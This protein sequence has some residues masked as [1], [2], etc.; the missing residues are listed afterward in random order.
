ML[1]PRIYRAGFVA[2]ALALVVLAFSLQNQPGSLG[3]TLPPDAFNGQ[4]AYASMLSVAASDPLR[5]PGSEGDDALATQVAN[6]LGENGFSVHKSTFTGRTV[7]GSRTLVNVTAIRPG[8]S[9]GTILVVAHRDALGSP[10]TAELSGTATL[11][12]LARDLAGETLN[13]TV[14]LASTSGSAGTAGAIRLASTV[15]GR[16]DAVIVL[17]DLATAHVREPIIVPWSDGQRVAPPLLRNTVAAALGAQTGLRAGGTSIA[18]QFVHLAFPLTISEQGPFGARGEPA[19]LLSL[20][21]ERGPA[22][23]AAIQGTAQITAMGRTVLQTISALDN[24][25]TVP[26]PSTYM[27]L[28]GKVVPGWAIELFVLALIVPVLLTTVDGVARARRRGHVIWRWVI[29]VLAGALPFALALLVVLGARLT[30]AISAA[31]AGPVGPGAVPLHGA[32][33]AVMAV[34]ACVLVLSFGLLRPLVI[35]Q[36][37]GQ[38]SAAHHAGEPA[39]AGAGAAVLLVLCVVT[40]GIWFTDPI[41]AALIVPALH[42]WMW[43]VTPQVRLRAPVLLLLF[44]AGLAPPVL[45]VLYYSHTLGFGPVAVAWDG[46]LLMAGGDI[47]VLA[48]LEWCVVLGCVASVAVIA[49]RAARSDHPEQTPVT[50]RGPITYAGP[51]S[52]GGTESALRR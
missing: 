3:T 30:G 37:G 29:W 4:N 5:R 52:L 13:H 16:I 11:I 27:L 17:G 19:V 18:G 39:S 35:R 47:G 36:A 2:V 23:D 31:P 10:A 45:V 20:S 33:I 22:A 41:A 8:I 48:A 46:V 38:P 7:D 43:V 24:G 1:D 21:G 50:V 14:V 34:A 6:S 15:G 26:P 28:S 12:E 42:L 40:I 32:G 49:V 44:L 51:G 25:A 9:T